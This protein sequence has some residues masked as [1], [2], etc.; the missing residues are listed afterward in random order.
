VLQQLRAIR[1]VTRVVRFGQDGRPAGD[2]G[3][4]AEALAAKG[5]YLSMTF[6][7]SVARAFG[8]RGLSL[9]TL[10]NDREP[11][12]LVH[13]Q[14]QHLCLAVEAGVPLEPVVAQV[15]SLLSRPASR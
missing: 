10:E 7:T 6:A 8:L 2:A 4:E 14:S 3:A 13:S 9:A 1:G 12:I 5:L 15:R 11:F